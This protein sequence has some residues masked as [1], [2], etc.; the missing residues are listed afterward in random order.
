M[1]N[2]ANQASVWVWLQTR[3]HFTRLPTQNWTPLRN[4]RLDYPNFKVYPRVYPTN[5][6]IKLANFSKSAPRLSRMRCTCGT[7]RSTIHLPRSIG[8]SVA[9]R[10]KRTRRGPRGRRHGTRPPSR[11]S[12]AC[13]RT[14]DIGCI[15]TI[16][17]YRVV[18]DY[19]SQ[20]SRKS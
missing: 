2:L 7:H 15:V 17:G 3:T 18:Y 10:R 8:R 14:V 12:S 11:G 20:F 9:P 19:L 4:L 16:I 13:Y 6:N 1:E 5:V